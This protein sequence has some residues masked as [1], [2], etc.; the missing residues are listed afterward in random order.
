[1]NHTYLK[2]VE[3]EEGGEGCGLREAMLIL[4]DTSHTEAYVY[5]GI[6][7]FNFIIFVFTLDDNMSAMNTSVDINVIIMLYVVY[8]YVY[9]I[10]LIVS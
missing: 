4:Y 7:F 3:R 10:T 8:I 6:I 2:R 9:S 5:K 1:M